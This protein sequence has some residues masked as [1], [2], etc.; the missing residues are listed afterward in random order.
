[1]RKLR[2]LLSFAALAAATCVASN[3]VASGALA[4]DAPW[5]MF[6]GPQGNGAVCGSRLP[7]HWSETN[8]VRWKVAIPD[9]GWSSPAVAA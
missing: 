6:R 4:A 8:N 7:L 9:A 1:M 2:P 3:F 5:P